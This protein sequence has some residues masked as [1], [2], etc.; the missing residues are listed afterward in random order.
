MRMKWRWLIGRLTT[1]GVLRL[2]DTESSPH[3]GP[4]IRRW[5]V[6]PALAEMG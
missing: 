5:Q 4:R 6:N 3:R 1:A 2:M